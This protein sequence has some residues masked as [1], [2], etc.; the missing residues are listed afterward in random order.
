MNFIVCL[1]IDFN[2][3]YVYTETGILVDAI[4]YDDEV[5]IVGKP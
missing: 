5:Q 2:K 4:C 3:F 1:S